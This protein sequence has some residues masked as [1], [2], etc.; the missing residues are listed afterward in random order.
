MTRTD[1]RLSKGLR[2]GERRGEVALTLQNIG[3]PYQDHNPNF[4]VQRGAF[5][6]LRLDN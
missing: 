2:W 5:V 4:T 3:L 1:V 6:T